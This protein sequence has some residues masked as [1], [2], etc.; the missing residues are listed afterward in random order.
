MA[1]RTGSQRRDPLRSHARGRW[2]N[3]SARAFGAWYEMFPRSAGADPARSATFARGAARLP[4][5]AAMGFDVLYLPPIHPIGRSFRKGPNNT[6]DA[7]PDDPGSPWAIGVGGGRP[8]GRRAR[9]SARWTTSTAS[10][11]AARAARPRGRARHRLPGSPDHPWVA[12]A[13]RMVPPPPGRHD[14]VRGEPA[15]EVPGHLSAQLRVR[16]LA[17]AVGR[18]EGR[19]SILDRARR[20]DLPRRQPAHQAVRVLGVGDRRGQARAP[21]GD[22]PRRGVHPAE[23]DAATGQVRVLAVLHLLHL[24]QHEGGA[25]RVPHRADA[26]RACASTCGRTSSPTRRTSCTSTCRGRPAGLPGPPGAGG[27]AGGELRHL[28]RRSSCARTCP[29]ARAARSTSTPRSTR[30][31]LRDCDAPGSLSELIAPDQHDPPRHTRRCSTTGASRSTPTDNDQT[32]LL[33]QALA[34]RPRYRARRGE[35]RPATS[36]HGWV[37]AAAGGL[38]RRARRARIEVARPARRRHATSGAAR[39]TTSALRSAGPR[40]PTSCDVRLTARTDVDY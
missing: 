12:R 23:G 33:Q 26:D 2:S 13:S 36:Q 24:A 25:D 5:V 37:H 30:S 31:A 22:L 8:H 4:Y 11:A 28:Q 16:G 10:S 17:G 6:L 18:A 27:D 9:R 21:R 39:G 19:R 38:G 40:R 15:E 29:C 7:G 3:A 34:G 32:A 14:Q 20:H 1:A 35:P